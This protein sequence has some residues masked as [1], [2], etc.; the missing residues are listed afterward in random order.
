MPTPEAELAAFLGRVPFNARGR[1]RY[2]AEPVA[3]PERLTV[4]P[5]AVVSTQTGFGQIMNEIA[6]SETPLAERIVSMSPDVT[7][8]TNLGPWVNRRG[9][10]ARES[11]ADLFR[12]ERIASTQRWEFSPKG[13]HVELGIAEMNLFLSLAAFGLAHSLFGAAA[14][15]RRHALRPVHRARARCAELRLLPGCPLPP[16]RHPV[17]HLARARRAART[18]RSARR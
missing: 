9:L 2:H 3:V 6:R 1:R 4:A 18:S 7:V 14:A 13:Q 11:V 15:S 10:F 8:S 5:Q 16:R 12:E 17:R